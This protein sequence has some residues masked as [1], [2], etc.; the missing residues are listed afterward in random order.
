MCVGSCLV[1]LLLCRNGIAMVPVLFTFYIQGVLK[2]KK[3]NNS[4]SKSLRNTTKICAC[5]DIIKKAQFSLLETSV[6][7]ANLF[8][9]VPLYVTFVPSPVLVAQHWGAGDQ[10]LC[11]GTTN[12]FFHLRCWP[13]N[14][15]QYATGSSLSSYYLKLI[16]AARPYRCWS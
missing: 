5:F 2:F 16:T 6:P 8:D 11:S 3:K 12:F 7:V 1:L 4:S 9:E 13:G 15:G 10:S 14:N